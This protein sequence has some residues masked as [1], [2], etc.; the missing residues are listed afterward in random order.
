LSAPTVTAQ[1]GQGK[2]VTVSAAGDGWQVEMK[3]DGRQ[4]AGWVDGR[5]LDQILP[6]LKMHLEWLEQ[7]EARKK[8]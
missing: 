7:S 4:W 1:I 3:L 8:Y 2:I 5:S 6:T